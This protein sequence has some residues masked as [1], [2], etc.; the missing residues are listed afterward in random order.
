M[1]RTSLLAASLSICLLL[2]V[3]GAAMA[4]TTYATAW[5]AAYPNACTT[6]RNAATSCILC[7]TNNMPDVNAYGDLLVSNNRNYLGAAS[8]DSDGDGRTNGQEI[9]EDCTLPGDL[10]SPTAEWTWGTLKATYR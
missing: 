2:C 6:L 7:H 10:T 4:K 3:A 9:N 5:K 1:K 8:A